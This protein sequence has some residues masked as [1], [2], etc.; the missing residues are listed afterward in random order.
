MALAPKKFAQ[1]MARHEHRDES[2]GFVYQYHPRSDAHSVALCRFII[3]DLLATCD[4]LREQALAGTVVYGI[5]YSHVFPLNKKKKTLDLAIGAGAPDTTKESVPGIYQGTISTLLFACES[6]T[7]MTE[8]AKSQPRIF[9]EL[10]SSHEIV[11]QGEGNQ[12][13]AAGITV[14]N[15][16][17]TFVSPLRQKSTTLHITTHKQPQA[18]ERMIRHLRGL[19]IRDES[20]GVGFDAYANIVINCDNQHPAKLH[21]KPPAPQPGDADEYG[22]FL[23]RVSSLYRD[24]F[25][26][27][28]R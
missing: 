8:H 9:D 17:A 3:Q 28:T 24:R 18:A 16:A 4:T 26:K 14:V 21:T 15:I 2:Y 1:W 19:P 13:I 5:N 22:T 11:H 23:T 7:N 25:G 10:S 12:V 6:K 20:E 27:K